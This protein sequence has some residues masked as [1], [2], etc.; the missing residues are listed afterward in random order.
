MYVHK[1]TNKIRAEVENML[2]LYERQ[3][4]VEC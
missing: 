4:V 3:L 1:Q 2:P